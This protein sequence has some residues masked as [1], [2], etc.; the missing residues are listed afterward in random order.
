MLTDIDTTRYKNVFEYIDA[1]DNIKILI[2]YCKYDE[3]DPNADNGFVNGNY[4]LTEKEKETVMN[5]MKKSSVEI[6]SSGIG[7]ACVSSLK[8][9]YERKN[10]QYYVSYYQFFAMTS[11]DGNI[12]KI[13]DKTVNNT[14]KEPQYCLYNFN[15]L[16]STAIT[17]QNRLTGN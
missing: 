14:L 9:T 1:Q 12:Y 10:K 2:N 5:E 16:S 15:N 13:I 4:E 8:I 3:N 17:I 7:G 11:N 6:A